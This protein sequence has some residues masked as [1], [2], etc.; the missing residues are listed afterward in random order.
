MFN[1]IEKDNESIAVLDKALFI[2]GKD[3]TIE[4]FNLNKLNDIPTKYIGKYNLLAEYDKDVVFFYSFNEIQYSNNY[5]ELSANFK[6]EEG[7]LKLLININS[8][9]Q[10]KNTQIIPI[11]IDLNTYLEQ[12]INLIKMNECFD[13]FSPQII[14]NEINQIKQD[15]FIECLENN[16]FLA[17]D[18][19]LHCDVEVY[20]NVDE[21]EILYGKCNRIIF[22]FLN[23]RIFLCEFIRNTNIKDFD[24]DE[25]FK[26]RILIND[27]ILLTLPN[28]KNN[29]GL[30]LSISYFQYTFGSTDILIE[31][32]NNSAKDFFD[33]VKDEFNKITSSINYLDYQSF[34]SMSI[35][36]DTNSILNN[37]FNRLNYVNTKE[38]LMDFYKINKIKNINYINLDKYLL[39]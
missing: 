9:I 35:S 27:K 12:I 31:N 11:E 32:S 14:T 4:N 21:E 16:M 10:D 18:N 6:Y 30:L 22:D 39:M 29:K 33:N 26:L 7:T 19:E 3:Y 20:S 2:P 37:F 5:V 25:D 28:M 8:F 24:L 23:N 17:I 15:M 36:N 34:L 38:Q 13:C 1:I